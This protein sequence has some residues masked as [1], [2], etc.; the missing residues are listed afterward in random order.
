MP[1]PGDRCDVREVPAEEIGAINGMCVMPGV[2]PAG[3][4]AEAARVHRAVARMGVRTFGA[5]QEGRP[6]G[7]LEV[8]PVD[9]APLPLEGEGLWVIRCL[10][11][12]EEAARQGLARSLMERALEAA[13]GSAGL[14]VLTYA[15]WMPVA[16]FEHF[17][18]EMVERR[19]P[20]ALLL[21]RLRPD[22]RVALAAGPR[23]SA[24]AP[25]P[26]QASTPAAA[27]ARA[28]PVVHVAA[29]VTG[30]CPW[31]MQM[32]RRRL[33]AARAL[34]S[35]VQTAEQLILDRADALRLGE[36]NIYIDGEPLDDLVMPLQAFL[37]RIRARLAP[38]T[39]GVGARPGEVDPL[40]SGRLA[41]GRL[42]R[43]FRS[44][45]TTKHIRHRLKLAG[46]D[47]A[48][49]G[50][51][52][53]RPP[54][55]GLQRSAAAYRPLRPP[56]PNGA[57]GSAGTG[58]D[59]D[60][61]DAVM[62]TE[63]QAPQAVPSTSWPCAWCCFGRRP[64]RSATRPSVIGYPDI[65]KAWLARCIGRPRPFPLVRRA[66]PLV[67]QRS[68]RQVCV[69]R[70]GSESARLSP[71]RPAASCFEAAKSQTGRGARP[72]PGSRPRR[73]PGARAG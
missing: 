37:D 54:S 41:A 64:Q 60:L 11:V 59:H 31:M 38:R 39:Y 3:A 42:T 36:E 5:F 29:V 71:F 68:M 4:L 28:E 8:M 57:S 51:Q 72:R 21:K 33:E 34:S 32:C 27:R 62:A 45:A 44:A 49:C 26:T 50:R 14:A 15:G 73:R 66:M 18:F 67:K 22:G 58:G 43:S 9:A 20:A 65:P 16:F 63:W 47:Q 10:W 52:D 12:L 13:A 70:P 1:E 2:A 6:V 7:R 23:P 17:G 61:V 55:A 48:L 30:R 19:G 46:A 40:P 25:A 35:R 56:Q 24:L 53:T 69:V